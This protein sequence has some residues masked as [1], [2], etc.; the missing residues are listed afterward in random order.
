MYVV[1][2]S[3]DGNGLAA[4]MA[5]SG[6]GSITSKSSLVSSVYPW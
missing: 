2:V 1:E 3:H 5:E 4:P 6:P